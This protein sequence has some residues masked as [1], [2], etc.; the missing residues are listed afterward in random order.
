M[1]LFYLKRH[2][3]AEDAEGAEEFK[4]LGAVMSSLFLCVLRVLCGSI[5]F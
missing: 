2:F 4:G 5:G 1:A 3:T